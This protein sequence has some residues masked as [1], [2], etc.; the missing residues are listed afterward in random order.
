MPRGISGANISNMTVDALMKLRDQ[1]DEV[2]T[3]KVTDERYQLEQQLRQ[4]SRYSGNAGR[5]SRSRHMTAGTS[6]AP[7]YRNPDN[8]AETWAGRG[9][10]PR[11]LTAAMK[12]GKKLEDFAIDG[13]A[14]A[15]AAKNT[16]RAR[17]K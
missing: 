10:K 11:W 4:L 6:V 8:P 16:R 5:S 7:K 15:S 1:I 9:L 3:S 17:K 2:L 13:P 14:K 12:G